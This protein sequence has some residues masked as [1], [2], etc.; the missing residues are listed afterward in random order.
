MIHIKESIN[1]FKTTWDEL[2]P[3]FI[4]TVTISHFAVNFAH[5]FLSFRTVKHFCTWATFSPNPTSINEIM[6]NY[7]RWHITGTWLSGIVSPVSL[8]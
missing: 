6:I 2:N 4:T 3:D 7:F 5:L 1:P 8:H